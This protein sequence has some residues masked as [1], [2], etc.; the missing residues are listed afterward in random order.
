MKNF[1]IFQLF[2]WVILKNSIATKNLSSALE[3]LYMWD[4]PVIAVIRSWRILENFDL[5]DCRKRPARES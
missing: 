1:G 4:P 2:G 3:F 5:A